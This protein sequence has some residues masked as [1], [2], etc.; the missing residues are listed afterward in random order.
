MGGLAARQQG[1][2]VVGRVRVRVALAAAALGRHVAEHHGVARRRRQGLDALR[3]L[4]PL[5][6]L[7]EV[8]PLRLAARLRPGW[9]DRRV[10]T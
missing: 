1:A 9:G 10:K 8:D 7:A 2:L 4:A 6:H 5:W 3:L